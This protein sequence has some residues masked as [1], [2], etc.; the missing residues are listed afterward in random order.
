MAPRRARWPVTWF[1][2]VAT[3]VLLAQGIQGAGELDESTSAAGHRVP[4]SDE[5]YVTLLYTD[6][7]LLGARVL[8][9]SLRLTFT[10]R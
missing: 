6:S 5:A 1:A 4:R 2:L 8:T 9:H 7:F 3:L 10:K